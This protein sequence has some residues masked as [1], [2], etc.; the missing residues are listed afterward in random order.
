MFKKIVLFILLAVSI[1]T[2]YSQTVAYVANNQSNS[3]SVIDTA[4]NT[5]TATIPVGDGPSGAVFSPDG[6][7]V[8][9]MNTR[10]DII[11]VIDTATNTVA[12]SIA[13][14]GIAIDGPE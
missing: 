2:V 3:V 8:Y 13:L 5:V 1:P 9:V 11:S 10:D 7:R 4:T 6:T 14:G 12:A